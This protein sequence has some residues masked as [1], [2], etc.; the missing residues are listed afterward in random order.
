MRKK[1]FASALLT[2]V[3]I[4]VGGQSLRKTEKIDRSQVPISIR[5]AIEKDFGKIP[6]DGYWFATFIVTK[7]NSR[8]VAKPL[9]YIYHK[10]D[11]VVKIEIRYSATGEL[12]YA[13]GI[14]K[15]T[16]SS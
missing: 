6:E 10:K 8:S 7:D 3:M 4:S 9:A 12:E 16:S 14:E 1:I 13:K 2:T 15:S 5:Q 11:R